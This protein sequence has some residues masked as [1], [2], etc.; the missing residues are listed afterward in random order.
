MTGL[1]EVVGALADRADVAAVVVVSS[2]GLPIQHAGRRALDA[3]AVAA[4]AAG[5]ARSARALTEVA[6][7]GPC[8]TAV[9]EGSAGLVVAARLDP[10]DWLLVLPEAGAEAGALLYDLRRHRSALA[11]LL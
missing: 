4:L 5:L 8:D 2:D 1:G 6:G 10:Q 11:A 7:L 9:L 3:E